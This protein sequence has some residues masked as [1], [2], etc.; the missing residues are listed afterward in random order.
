MQSIANVSLALFLWT[1]L[2]GSSVAVAGWDEG[3][4]AFKAKEYRQ[5]S[6]LFADYA[7]Q[8]PKAP[9]VHYMLG[10]SLVQQN[11]VMEALGPLGDALQL[12][13]DEASYRLALAQA[14][15]KAHRADAAVATLAGQD[16]DTLPAAQE[17]A[18]ATLMARAATEGQNKDAAYAA[19]ERILKQH[20]LATSLWLAK[21]RLERHRGDNQRAFGALAKA[22]ELGNDVEVGEQAVHSAFSLARAAVGESRQTWYQTSSRLA[23]QL[24]RQ[25]PTSEYRLL[26]GEASMGA[27]DLAAA[28]G[29][30]RQAIAQ[31]S[32]DNIEDPLPHYYLARCALA[33]QQGEAALAHL[34]AAEKRSPDAELKTQILLT[35]AGAYRQMED[36]AKAAE[37]YRQAM[38]TDKAEE[39]ERLIAAKKINADWDEAHR[40]C[41]QKRQDIQELMA[42]SEDLRG[43]AAWQDLE[44]AHEHMLAECKTY[45]EAST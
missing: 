16:L 22:Y 25:Q 35:R 21:A 45:F 5:A 17:T 3:V 33:E 18:Y 2:A 40:A 30:F 8:N 36:F 42:D 38:R 11:R 31:Q 39:M 14:Q 1:V 32:E 28:S 41:K 29:W 26:A 9:Q 37:I 23:S 24:A 19:V 7:K 27:G 10:L 12:S 4:A 6:E 44:A 15:L 13:P 20:P 34:T 43:T